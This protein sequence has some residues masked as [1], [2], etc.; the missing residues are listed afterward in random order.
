MLRAVPESWFSSN[1]GIYEAEAPAASHPLARV[2]LSRIKEAGELTIEDVGHRMR[3]EGL[4][5]GAFVLE[6]EGSE[7]ARADKPSAFFNRFE[8]G[9][10]GQSYEL[11]KDSIW[12][13]RFVVLGGAERWWAR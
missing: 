5:S 4:V 8:I 10:R 7:L 3:R 9:H 12:R 2:S 13:R 1:F 11:K 6:R